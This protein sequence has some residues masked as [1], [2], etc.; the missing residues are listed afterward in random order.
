M[1]LYNLLNDYTNAA[2]DTVSL[3]TSSNII[4]S[5]LSIA[6]NTNLTA[7]IGLAK[8]GRIGFDGYAGFSH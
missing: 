3:T 6:P 7:D 5:T 8:V 1:P 2:A 4:G